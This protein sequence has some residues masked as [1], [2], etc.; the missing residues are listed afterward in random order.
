MMVASDWL[1]DSE[2]RIEQLQSNMEHTADNGNEGVNNSSDSDTEV[3]LQL[4]KSKKTYQCTECQQ[5]FNSWRGLK[6]H[7]RL[8]SGEKPYTCPQCGKVLSELYSFKRHQ[9]VHSGATPYTCTDCGKH[10]KSVGEMRNHRV[11]I[12]SVGHGHRCEHCDKLFVAPSALSRHLRKHTGDK[13]YVCFQ[14][15]K[16]FTQSSTL[17]E[18][19]L[20]HSELKPFSCPLCSRP[21]RRK[22]DADTHLRKSCP[23]KRIKWFNWIMSAAAAFTFVL[24]QCIFTKYFCLCCVI[25]RLLCLR[26]EAV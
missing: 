22:Q 2:Q 15:D 21:F 10:F 1:L 23:L 25:A 20:I 13:P 4:D 18:H 5:E 9:R 8:H 7:S 16:K 24:C 12:H 6:T 3:K 26:Y 19:C 11:R 17:K 14:C